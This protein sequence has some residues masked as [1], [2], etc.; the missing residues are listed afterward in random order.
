MAQK[1]SKVIGI[2]LGTTKSVA[3]VMEGG[4]TQVIPNQEGMR[5][6]P[7]VVAFTNKGEIL[8]GQIAKRQAL[9]NPQ[10]TFYSVKRLVGRRFDSPEIQVAR[11]MLPYEIVEAANGD[12][13]VQIEDRV[14]SPP[15]VSAVVLEKLK[16]ATEDYI[17][18]AVEEAILTVP[19]SFN[20]RQRQATKDAGTIAGLEVQRI[21]NA[22]TSAALACGVIYQNTGRVAVYD[23]GGGHFNISIVEIRDGIYG[24]LSSGGDT[25]LGGD[26]FDQLII[27]WLVEE[28]KIDL[29]GDRRALQRLKEAAEKAKCELS[30]QAQAEIVLPFISAD[31]SGPKHLNTVLTR[32]SFE[33]MIGPL[34][35]RTIEPC[36]Q[37]L[38]DSGLKPDDIDD[39]VLVGGQTRTPAVM[40]TVRSVFGKVPYLSVNTDELVAI[41]AAI[42]AGILKGEVTDLV[43]L[44]VTPQ[45]LGIESRD[46]S[47]IPII[48]RNSSI[49]TKK[50]RIFTTDTDNQT[51]F[52]VHVLQGEYESDHY[53]LSLGK[54]E[55]TGIAPAPK[56]EP[57]IEVTFEID[58][59]G[60]L[61]V[62]A[63]DQA[64]GRQ[65]ELNVG[66]SSDLT[67][68]LIVRA[69]TDAEEDAALE[70]EFTKRARLVGQLQV[71][72][73][74]TRNIYE[75][76][77]ARLTDEERDFADQAFT[78]AETA[79]EG[80]LEEVQA[81][82]SN[83]EATAEILG[84]AM[85][86]G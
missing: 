71:L 50:S 12:A 8:V 6:T 45:A 76:L 18:E 49:P 26:D 51:S 4:T 60:I 72:L 28:F 74:S 5:T 78:K 37:A 44:D 77:L 52:V 42:Q 27:N 86:R 81:A 30:T 36:R 43:L 65:Q 68:S 29:A 11:K 20:D 24:V 83:L 75:L 9:T 31:A 61:Q 82:L 79:G 23:L 54:F 85:L 84:Q 15:E 34:L 41:G 70:D 35:A 1:M 73:Q 39:V 16:A 56:G 7:S 14:Y 66:A 62:T 69:P 57:Q 22:S 67:Q 48:E 13:Y 80:S 32:P 2:D 53:S 63:R 59:N 10:N 25:Y 58:V 38:E 3:V 47:F 55:L 17:G 46:G 33:Q 19:A 21:L 64:T 40:E